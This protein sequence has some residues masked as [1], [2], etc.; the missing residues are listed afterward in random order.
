[1]ETKSKEAMVV[2]YEWLQDAI[3]NDYTAEEWCDLAKML[4][5]YG[6]GNYDYVP[7]E[8]INRKGAKNILDCIKYNNEKYSNASEVNSS[9]GKDGGVKSGVTR[10][11]NMIKRVLKEQKQIE[12]N[13][14]FLKR[15]EANASIMKRNEADT[16]TDTGTDTDTD[17]DSVTIEEISPIVVVENFDNG[18]LPYKSV[19][20]V[21]HKVF[22]N[23]AGS[24]D[25]KYSKSVV[26]SDNF[27]YWRTAVNCVYFTG[28][29]IASILKIGTTI[30]NAIKIF[31]NRQAMK[32]IQK[33]IE[34]VCK[35]GKYANKPTDEKARILIGSIN[36]FERDCKQ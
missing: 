19:L 25:E 21:A 33:I 7:V 32:S 12:A 34:N 13:A 9:N 5:E 3:E 8:R 10:H 15:N 11:L 20:I 6:N 14:S 30:D 2:K 24:N 36:K 23:H 29:D 17:T 27:L 22:C 35:E 26:E 28:A 18:N 1:M 4:I 16:D 31:G